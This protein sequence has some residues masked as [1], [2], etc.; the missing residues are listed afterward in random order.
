MQQIME[1][2]LPSR[3]A[4]SAAGSQLKRSCSR[5]FKPLPMASVMAISPTTV[6]EQSTGSNRA[7]KSELVRREWVLRA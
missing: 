3:S 5:V 1:L 7:R 4:L 6:M 2:R